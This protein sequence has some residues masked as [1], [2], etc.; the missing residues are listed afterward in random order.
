VHDQESVVIGGLIQERE[1][2]S[3]TKVPLLGDIPLLGY[4][5][6]YQTTQKVKTDLLILLTPYII[7]DRLDLE[8][9]R[10]RKLQQYR[11]FTQSF[12]NLNE[13]KYEPNIDYRRKRG[14]VEEINRSLQ[15]VEE[16]QE[17][18]NAAGHRQHVNEGAIE[19]HPA[20]G[21]DEPAPPPPPSGN[22]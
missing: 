4:L 10:T 1:V 8:A 6:K 14:L 19:F 16:D 5:F 20:N 3:V 21:G 15:S 11:E 9:V 17:L 18:L 7:K 12:S 2:Y 22:R 13:A